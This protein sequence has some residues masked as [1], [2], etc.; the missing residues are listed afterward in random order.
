MNHG[1]IELEYAKLTREVAR[2]FYGRKSVHALLLNL[3][4]RHEWAKEELLA[5]ELGLAPRQVHKVLRELQKDLI[6]S[7]VVLK[8]KEVGRF[9][10]NS[11][12]YCCLDYKSMVDTCRLKFHLVRRYLKGEEEESKLAVL[13]CPDCGKKYSALET[14]TL[15]VGADFMFLCEDCEA[16]LED[17]NQSDESGQKEKQKELSKTFEK[18]LQ[19]FGDLLNRYVTFCWHGGDR[20]VLTLFFSFPLSGSSRSLRLTLAPC[21]S[22][23]RRRPRSGR[24]SRTA[25]PIS[26]TRRRTL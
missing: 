11:Q 15:E 14:S 5:K 6:V 4:T 22:G 10:S 1:E 20:F 3:L 8:D 25:T 7:R 16:T 13:V 18:E 9:G 2:L 17:G 19:P 21:R 24:R 12:S 26:L 23:R